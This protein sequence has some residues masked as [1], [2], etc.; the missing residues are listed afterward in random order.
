MRATY[1]DKLCN[2]AFSAEFQSS[3]EKVVPLRG[4]NELN[5]NSIEWNKVE[6]NGTKWSI[7][8][9]QSATAFVFDYIEA[10]IA[11]RETSQ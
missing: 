8:R 4:G 5:L 11:V 9:S 7:R 1:L 10:K 3:P 6:W 2:D